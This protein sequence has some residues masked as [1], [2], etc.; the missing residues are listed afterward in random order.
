M[1][2]VQPARRPRTFMVTLAYD[3]S[4]F[5][6]WQIQPGEP[7]IQGEL[8]AAVRRVTGE[9]PL[10]QG[11]GR[12]D[13][14][15]HALGQVASFALEAT[16]PPENLRRALNRTLPQAIRIV[17]ARVVGDAFH[18]RHSAVAK[19]YEYRVFREAVCP[20]FLARY[21]YA[22]AWPVRLELLE[23]SAGMFVGEHDFLSFAAT[24]PDL[25]SR[26]TFAGSSGAK[27]EDSMEEAVE[28]SERW[29]HSHH[30]LFCLGTAR[31]GAW[32]A[33]GL[34]GA[35]QRVS[36]SYG[37]QS[38]GHHAGCGTGV[39][40]DRTDS[41]NSG[42]TVAGWW[43]TDRTGERAVSALGGI[44]AGRWAG[45][46]RFE[47]G[48]DDSV[49]CWRPASQRPSGTRV[50]KYAPVPGGCIRLPWAILIRSL[51]DEVRDLLSPGKTMSQLRQQNPFVRLLC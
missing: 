43:R 6:G 8:Q 9:S 20:P 16:I 30:L 51:R 28:A 29:G 11:S 13:A 49:F 33:A 50:R 15:V 41:R 7:T 25:T 40:G 2:F 27:A 4:D 46:P 36:A 5:S 39:C 21:V 10:P 35:R 31:V 23:R 37:A 38:G 17:D 14:G 45:F 48:Q 22:C 42:G 26:A 18:A 44:P 12:T 34:S 3:G 47:N 32:R 24:D 19:T 1:E